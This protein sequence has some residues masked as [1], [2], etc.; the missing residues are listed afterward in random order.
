MPLTKIIAL[1]LAIGVSAWIWLSGKKEIEHVTKKKKNSVPTK[2]KSGIDTTKL[3]TEPALSV[4]PTEAPVTPKEHITY[5]IQHGDYP[6]GLAKRFTGDGNRWREILPLNPQL[7]RHSKTGNITN[8]HP[9]V[10]IKVPDSW[11]K[12]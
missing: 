9:G 6:V 11:G 3:V 4:S 5:T 1:G 2:G 10:V 7:K 8:F 12:K